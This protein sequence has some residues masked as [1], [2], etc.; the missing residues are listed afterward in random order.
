MKEYNVCEATCG[1]PFGKKDGKPQVCYA[2]EV[3]SGFTGKEKIK[4]ERKNETQTQP[5]RMG[6]Q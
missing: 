3:C 6:R 1:C 2:A 5:E 4:K